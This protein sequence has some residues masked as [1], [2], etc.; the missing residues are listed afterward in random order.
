[1]ARIPPLGVTGYHTRMPYTRRS[2]P[3]QTAVAHSPNPVRLHYITLTGSAG[4]VATDYGL[5]SP[6]MSVVR[7]AVGRYTITFPGGGGP[8]SPARGWLTCSLLNPTVQGTLLT[9]YAAGVQDFQNGIA[10]IRLLNAAGGGVDLVGTAT[11]LVYCLCDH[12]NN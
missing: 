4:A 10:Q 8:P 3:F 11:V 7:T 9:C 1:M 6:G 12:P 5:S 2:G